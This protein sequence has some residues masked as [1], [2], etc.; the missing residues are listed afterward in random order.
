M[1]FPLFRVGSV[2][3]YRFQ[4]DGVRIQRSTH[5]TVKHRAEAVA[6]CAYRHARLWARGAL[7]PTLRQLVREWL[8][9]HETIR[10]HAY[11]RNVETF[12]RL[13][14]YG[15]AD[16]LVDE[17]TTPLVETAMLD[18]RRS[19]AAASVNHWLNLL[20]VVCKWAVRR[21][22]MP[23]I[24]WSVKALKVQ[25][26]P[27]ATLPVSRVAEWL[28][29]VDDY[30]LDCPGLSIAVRLAFGLGLRESEIITAR[31]DW[32]D[33]ERGTYTPGVTKGREADPIPMSD[34]LIDYLR[35]RRQPVGLIVTRRRGQA[36]R[37]GF[38]RP[39]LR[40]ANA[41][42]QLVGITP[43]RLRGTFATLLSENGASVSTIQRVMRHKD[44]MTTMRYLEANLATAALAQASIARIAGLQ[45]NP[46]QSGEKVA[47]STPQTRIDT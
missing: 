25:K 13:H 16:V 19:H 22:V 30:A 7:V 38:L 2:W 43:H 5:E 32:I 44:P 28:A 27:R 37:S 21:N 3:H 36:Y 10:S 12:G 15:L 45:I 23:T 11:I 4:I 34:W 18:H 20:K 42:C 14:L 9:A 46:E 39:V 1:K 33:W 41:A 26:R 29:A 40:S 24:P 47:N 8:A 6:E 35:T 17:L 31:W